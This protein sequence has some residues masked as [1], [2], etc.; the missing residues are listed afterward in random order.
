ME[1][2][3]KS[4]FKKKDKNKG[5]STEAISKT[6]VP[7]AKAENDVNGATANEIKVYTE[8]YDFKPGKEII[9]FD[10]FESEEV[11]EIP[12]KWKYNKGL[13]EVVKVD[14]DYNHVMS[15]DLGYGHPNWPDDFRLPEAYTIEFDVYAADG[16]TSPLPYGGSYGYNLYFDT[17]RY[18]R[19][20]GYINISSQGYM[21][22]GDVAE[23][24][25]PNTERS[26]Y[27]NS[28]NHISI[29]VSGSS[30]KAYFNDYRMF[31]SRFKEGG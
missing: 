1:D 5:K 3:V 15:G 2:G 23:K 27:Y 14:N 26:D 17:D 18:G 31:N 6:E 8:R 10:D 20:N 29:S 25:V 30:V 7:E 12:S 19:K 9:F 21:A 4:L 11:G 24:R 13:M 28:W 22:L 16:S